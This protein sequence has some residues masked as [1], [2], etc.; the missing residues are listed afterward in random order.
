MLDRGHSISDFVTQAGDSEWSLILR[1]FR[2][3]V[4]EGSKLQV[5]FSA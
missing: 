2:S 3:R 5:V 4:E 1:E